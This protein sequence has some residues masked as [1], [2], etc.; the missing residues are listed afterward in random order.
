MSAQR[1][2]RGERRD[3]V[4]GPIGGVNRRMSTT[5]LRD[6]GCYSQVSGAHIETQ[7]KG[8]GASIER[9]CAVPIR[10]GFGARVLSPAG[11]YRVKGSGALRKDLGMR[12]FGLRVSVLAGCYILLFLLYLWHTRFY[13]GNR[14][15]GSGCF[16][17][18]DLCGAG[19]GWFRGCGYFVVLAGRTRICAPQFG[20]V[21]GLCGTV[22]EAGPLQ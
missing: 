2:R 22:A 16:N 5:R 13:A 10:G 19:S 4:V 11:A 6:L 7:V 21:S 17:R 8:S 20:V 3:G 9:I 15:K 12:W 14:V 1:Q 18:K